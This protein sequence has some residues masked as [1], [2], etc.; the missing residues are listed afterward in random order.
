MRSSDFGS[1]NVNIPPAPQLAYP[2]LGYMYKGAGV[3][4]NLKIGR[5]SK[6]LS[7]FASIV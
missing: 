3:K 6:R 2:N 4:E 1:E 5:E 7:R